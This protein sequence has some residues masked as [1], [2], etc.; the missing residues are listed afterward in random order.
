[1]SM[2]NSTYAH[3][4]EDIANEIERRNSLR[5]GCEPG[6]L[7]REAERFFRETTG[8]NGGASLLIYGEQ[9]DPPM[10]KH[11]GKTILAEIMKR[12]LSG[13]GIESLPIHVVLQND[14]FGSNAQSFLGLESGRKIRKLGKQTYGHAPVTEAYVENVCSSIKKSL[15]FSGIP[16]TMLEQWGME[17]KSLIERSRETSIGE[18]NVGLRKIMEKIILPEEVERISLSEVEEN[19][20]HDYSDLRNFFGEFAGSYGFNVAWKKEDAR[21]NDDS[22]FRRFP[23]DIDEGGRVK[24]LDASNGKIAFE[25]KL[26]ETRENM[27]F[28]LNVKSRIAM[29]YL[30]TSRGAH[31]TAGRG[32]SYNVETSAE[33][34]E[35]RDKPLLTYLSLPKFMEKGAFSLSSMMGKKPAIEELFEEAEKINSTDSELFGKLTEGIGGRNG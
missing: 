31:I 1:M 23:A 29:I 24:I 17:E 34:R 14:I 7:E 22:G 2:N 16:T 12:K 13:R 33:W 28:G 10:I 25:G 30:L 18:F 8:I 20:I 27:E 32:A 26:E 11:V 6:A 3:D 21:G 15:K 5:N 4:L 9:A 35:K 19:L